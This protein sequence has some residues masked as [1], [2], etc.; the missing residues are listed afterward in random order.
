MDVVSLFPKYERVKNYID[1]VNL[2]KIT[3]LN[4]QME[5]ATRKKDNTA[6]AF[7]QS[8][9]KI[10]LKGG[11]SPETASPMRKNNNQAR[12]QLEKLRDLHIYNTN[13]TGAVT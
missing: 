11:Q 2:K 3:K 7:E 1:F 9:F 13:K 4:D 8:A 12:Y 6:V 5:R 10:N